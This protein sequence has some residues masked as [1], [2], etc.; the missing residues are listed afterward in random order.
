M[1]GAAAV[2]VRWGGGGRGS[3]NTGSSSRLGG[4]RVCVYGSCSIRLGGGG[5]VCMEAV[6]S[7]RGVECVCV[8][9]VCVGLQEAGGQAIGRS[10]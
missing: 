7:G 6:A 4:G 2:A 5:R 10:D 1:G 8:E 9:G 3:S